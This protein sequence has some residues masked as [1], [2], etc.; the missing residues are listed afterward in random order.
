MTMKKTI[1]VISVAGGTNMIA[2]ALEYYLWSRR[3]RV[4]GVHF[5]HT[6]DGLRVQ[7]DRV[8]IHGLAPHPTNTSAKP[9]YFDANF[10]GVPFR[11]SGSDIEI[12]QNRLAVDHDH[13]RGQ[14]RDNLVIVVDDPWQHYANAR[15]SVRA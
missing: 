2:A 14:L 10:G 12:F 1:P 15:H 11:V 6:S 5:G 8:Q 4:E 7:G 13:L 9:E 3:G